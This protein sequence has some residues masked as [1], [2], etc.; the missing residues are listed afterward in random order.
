MFKQSKYLI[1]YNNITSN[2]DTEGYTEIHHIIPRSLGGTDESTNLVKL[3]LRKHFICHLLLTKM[4]DDTK[5]LHKMLHALKMMSKTRR[6]N[7]YIYEKMKIK[8]KDLK[9]V[10][11]Y[12]PDTDEQLYLY[13][14]D[15][16]PLGFSIGGRPKSDKWKDSRKGISQSIEHKEKRLVNLSFNRGLHRFKHISSGQIKMFNDAPD[17]NWVSTV[18][19]KLGRKGQLPWYNPETSECKL[20]REND[21][22]PEGW[23]RGR[24][25]KGIRTGWQQTD[26]QRKAV[27]EANQC[28]Y[29][30]V[31]LDGREEI[32]TGFIAWINTQP[33]TKS[34]FG[35]KRLNGTLY[36]YGIKSFEKI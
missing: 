7:S 34:K 12:N 20:F 31:W 22:I 4:V 11:I 18:K 15:V 6:I 17:E 2:P 14:G 13:D 3:S 8:F 9:Y 29:K 36:E 24:G 30:L 28:S 27:K 26:T 35:T 33:F 1:W 10:L 5:S 16:I 25:P 21:I 23:V 32:I 19:Q